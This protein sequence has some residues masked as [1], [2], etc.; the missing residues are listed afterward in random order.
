M[1]RG[2]FSKKEGEIKMEYKLPVIITSLED[3][4]Y[5]AHCD[6]VRATATGNTPEEAV[7]NLHEA[8]KEMVQEFGKEAVF[9]DVTPD[10]DIQMLEVAL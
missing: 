8:I 6:L 2:K 7:K 4:S 1:L 9:Q 10:I 3:K 5:M